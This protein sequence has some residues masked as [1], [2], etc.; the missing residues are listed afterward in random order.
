MGLSVGI[1]TYLGV[2]FKR[3]KTNIITVVGMGVIKLRDIDRNTGGVGTK[4]AWLGEMFRLGFPVPEG[5]VVTSEAYDKFLVFNG[6]DERIKE[7]FSSADWDNVAAVGEK[8]RG[9]REAI[10]GLHMPTQVEKMIMD[11]YEDLSIGR[12]ARGLGGVAL[13]MIRAGRTPVYC[14]VRTS[15]INNSDFSFAGQTETYLNMNG[16]RTI[17][18]AIKRCW[19]SLFSLS[20]LYYMKRAWIGGEPKAGVVVQKMV[21]SEKSG[22]VLLSHPLAEGQMLLE[23]VWGLGETLGSGEVVPDSYALDSYGNVAGKRVGKKNVC[24]TK[25]GMSGRTITEIMPP[26]RAG[27]EVLYPEEVAKAVEVSRK[28]EAAFGANTCIEFGIEKGRLFVLQAKGMQAKKP[29]QDYLNTDGRDVVASGI[30]ASPGVIHGMVTMSSNFEDGFEPGILVA[31]NSRP[32]FGSI[33]GKVSGIVSETGGLSSHAAVVAREFSIPLIVGAD[34]VTS[35]LRQG[36]EIIVDAVRGEVLSESAR[37]MPATDMFG[38]TGSLLESDSRDQKGEELADR[39]TATEIKMTYPFEGPVDADGIGLVSGEMLIGADIYSFQGGNA[40]M[41]EALRQKLGNIARSIYPRSVWY[42][43][44]GSRSMPSMEMASPVDNIFGDVDAVPQGG[45]SEP[46]YGT[47]IMRCEFDAVKK[48]SEEGVNNICL[49]APSV[50]RAEELREFKRHLNFPIKVGISVEST[51]AVFIIEDLLKEG[52]GFVSIGL[53]ELSHNILGSSGRQ[54]GLIEPAVMKAIQFVIEAC[55]KNN[56]HVSVRGGAAG[57]PGVAAKLVELGAHSLSV[58]SS[59]V[60]AVR[61]AVARAEKR[62][63]LE[64][65]RRRG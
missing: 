29:Y 26:E 39:L 14:A 62:L 12:E 15:V 45:Q 1:K 52:I 57:N 63:L 49:M 40:E 30:P 10:I 50:T 53:D 59:Y 34:N 8:A 27:M 60:E 51:A 20:C 42:R 43:L 19:A 9:I 18:E 41:E 25:H 6:I 5:F 22:A 48:L 46:G 54:E 55:R 31:K 35:A 23:S 61:A 37:A 28:A 24:R 36:Q 13:D 16:N 58:A 4:A 3:I 32:D 65:L 7:F 33:I 2:G 44:T 47:D 64:M 56:V 21:N 17:L 38:F 11:E